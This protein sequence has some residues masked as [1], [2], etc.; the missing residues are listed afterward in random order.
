M[1]LPI[2]III[3]TPMQFNSSGESFGGR[4]PMGKYRGG[5]KDTVWKYVALICSRYGTGR[6]QQGTEKAGG[7]RSGRPQLQNN[8]SVIKTKKI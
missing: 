5:W 7:R 1:T 4:R 8:R 6:R 3:F 2:Y